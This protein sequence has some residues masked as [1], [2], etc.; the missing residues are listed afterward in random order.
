MA[1]ITIRNFDD[2]LKAK[3]RLQAAKHQ[4]SMEDEARSI[5]RAALSTNAAQDTSLARAIH[6]RLAPL[7][8]VEL[9]LPEREQVRT[10]PDFSA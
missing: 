8:G 3:L 2:R 1:A 5:L 7:G 6:T 10:P 4:R 9:E